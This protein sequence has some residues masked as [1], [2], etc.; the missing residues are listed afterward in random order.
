MLIVVAVLIVVAQPPLSRQV[1]RLTLVRMDLVRMDLVQL[2]LVLPTLV[3]TD[4]RQ[5]AL[6]QT[7]RAFLPQSVVWLSCVSWWFP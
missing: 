7:A 1:A 3:A 4:H 5:P 6:Q 2:T